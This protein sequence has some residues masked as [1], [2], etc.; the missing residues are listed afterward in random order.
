MSL[1]G[2]YTALVTPFNKDGEVDEEA[3]RGLI[4]RQVQAGVDGVV[5]VGTT[6]ESPTLDAEEHIRVIELTVEAADGRCEVIAGTGANSTAEALELTQAA[7]KAGA[8]GS[9]QVTPYYNKPSQ[10]GLYR[11]FR[12]I[13]GATSLPI[14]LYSIPGRCGI[15]IGLETVV[16]L[17]AEC[18]G[19]VALKEA[20]GNP[21]RV[22]EMRM[23]LPE[24]F[25]I[26]SGDD[27]MTV[28]FMAVGAQG[29]ISVAANLI[30]NE[31]Q[32][33]VTAA[34]ADDFDTAREL[35]L[36]WFDLFRAMFLETNPVPAKTALSL[37]GLIG[38][39]IRLPLCEM[40]EANLNTLTEVLQ[41]HNLLPEVA[42]GVEENS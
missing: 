32:R 17:A 41:R 35:H 16:R 10:E 1:K 31:L 37:M 8:D 14:V 20:S 28:P 5:A 26:L 18:P 4:E 15:E 25:S 13:A 39:E 34:L 21:D 38:D 6:G 36:E 27:S 12:E 40:T 24:D 33:M 23:N 7:E 3:L 30:P 29:V 19:I 11:H 42:D 9:L 2:A 22:S